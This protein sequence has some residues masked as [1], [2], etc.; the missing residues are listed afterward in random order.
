MLILPNIS[1]RHVYN[2]GF[3]RYRFCSAQQ[4]RTT[5]ARIEMQNVNN[6][7]CANC[8][9]VETE[10]K[11]KTELPTALTLL[12]LQNKKFPLVHLRSHRS[13]LL[14]VLLFFLSSTSVVLS[15]VS[16][17]PPSVVIALLMLTRLAIE[18]FLQT[19]SY[20]CSKL[21]W[22]PN[23]A[24]RRPEQLALGLSSTRKWL[25]V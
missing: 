24:S 14:C 13:S 16:M 22:V 19:Y 4:T 8:N 23:F 21:C 6:V 17:E 15:N 2:A 9:V 25:A 12:H 7:Y 5:D 10:L 20:L 1:F 18:P 3:E 11:V